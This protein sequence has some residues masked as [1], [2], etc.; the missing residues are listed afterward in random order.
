MTLTFIRHVRTL[1]QPHQPIPLFT[2]VLEILMSPEYQHVKLNVSRKSG[3]EEY[4]DPE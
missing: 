2:E 3:E 1:K 4:T